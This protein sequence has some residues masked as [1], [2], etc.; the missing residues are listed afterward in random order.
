MLQ[1]KGQSQEM[2]HDAY[3]F[4]MNKNQLEAVMTQKWKLVLPHAFNSLNGKMGGKDGALAAYEKISVDLALY[5]LINDEQELKNVAGDYPEIVHKLQAKADSIRQILG[6]KI[7][8]VSGTE[9]RPLG[10]IAQ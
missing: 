7:T 2:A 3:Y 4:Y 5:D 9:V 10:A 8:G 6:D 1:L